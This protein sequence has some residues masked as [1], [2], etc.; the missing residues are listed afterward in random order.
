MLN[1]AQLIT[2]KQSVTLTGHNRTVPPCSVGRRT[3]HTPGPAAVDRPRAL[4]T[5]TDDDD[6]QQRTKQYWT[7]RRASNNFTVNN[8]EMEQTHTFAV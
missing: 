3:G 1:T 6:I 7:I 4:Q 2:Q 5:T 8:K